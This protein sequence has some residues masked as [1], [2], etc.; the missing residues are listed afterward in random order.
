MSQP[1]LNK[2]QEFLIK[3]FIAFIV[4][5]KV[6]TID[7]RE[8]IIG[9]VDRSG[10]LQRS[11]L[12]IH[13][14]VE[15]ITYKL[16]AE[17]IGTMLLAEIYSTT[18]GFGDLA[19]K[20]RPTFSLYVDEF[21]NFATSDFAKL[22][23]QGGKFG[24]RQTVAHQWRNQLTVAANR[25]ATLSA[26]TQV[27]FRT[28]DGSEL[29][30]TFSDLSFYKRPE[31]FPSDV[32]KHLSTYKKSPEEF[33]NETVRQFA[34]IV[35]E[36]A[37]KNAKEK[38]LLLTWKVKITPRGFA[39]V[40]FDELLSELEL[41]LREAMELEE[42]DVRQT[43]RYLR[44]VGMLSIWLGFT[45]YFIVEYLAD[46]YQKEEVPPDHA[47]YY[48]YQDW[49]AT[50]EK[51]HED[52]VLA[53]QKKWHN[54]YVG[55]LDIVI[56]TLKRYPLGDVKETTDSERAAKLRDLEKGMAWVKIGSQSFVLNTFALDAIHSQQQHSV[57]KLERRKQHILKQTHNKYCRSR[58]EIEN[59][60]QEKEVF[61][62]K[63]T[64]EAEDFGTENKQG[65]WPRYEDI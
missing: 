1:L 5:Q 24:V 19:P 55:G 33:R 36:K 61:M 28:I 27:V 2:L 23:A 7:I 6:T 11:V 4:E 35:V 16:S 26:T 63:V 22:F 53:E 31:R 20:D 43:R 47:R 39:D 12:L 65:E 34:G 42:V 32:L 3:D 58:V 45:E 49:I 9:K 37:Q 10:K 64:E 46:N 62:H 60:L 18:F 17:L 15:D 40:T 57:I 52:D 41:L 59:E 54:V 56:D 30:K 8:A 50:T 14:P 13:L 21:Q 44:V 51:L 48:A 25:D 38:M 29:A